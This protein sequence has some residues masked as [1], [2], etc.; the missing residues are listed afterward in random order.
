LGVLLIS[1]DMEELIE[2]SDRVVVLKDG[3]V[4]EELTGDAVTEDRLMR[5]IAA[6]PAAQATTAAPATSGGDDD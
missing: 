2:G 3:A 4:V 6:A 1:S 5:A